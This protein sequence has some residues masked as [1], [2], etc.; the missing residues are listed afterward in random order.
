MAKIDFKDAQGRLDQLIEEAAAGEHVVIR[1]PR[2]SAVQLVPL[3][4]GP[5]EVSE[6]AKRA[7][8]LVESGIASWRGGK[9]RGSQPRPRI[10]GKS[11]SAMVLEDRR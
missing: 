9:P 8:R 3:L 6:T 10:K 7:W 1:G 4:E 11:L 5:I 2:G